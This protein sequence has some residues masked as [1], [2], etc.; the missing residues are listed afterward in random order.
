MDIVNFDNEVG[1]AGFS[2]T[3]K[4]DIREHIEDCGEPFIKEELE[5]LMQPP[6]GSDDDDDVI[7]NR[8]AQIGRCRSLPV[9]SGKRRS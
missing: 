8:E 1:G 4:K 5:E 9:F 7:E 2:D 6:K 3:V